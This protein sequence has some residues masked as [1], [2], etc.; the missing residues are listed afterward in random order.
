M[1]VDAALLEFFSNRPSTSLII[2]A[3]GTLCLNGFAVYFRITA[4]VGVEMSPT[5][6]TVATA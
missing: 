1:L 3:R 4:T 5:P 6:F 2:E